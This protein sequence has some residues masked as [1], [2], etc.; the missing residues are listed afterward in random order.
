VP[1][2][3]ALLVA[4][5]GGRELVR[6][7]RREPQV[8]A[9]WRAHAPL[10]AGP[11]G[12][13]VAQGE[14]AVYAADAEGR[15]TRLDACS[16]QAHGEM[17]LPRAP[18]QLVLAVDGQHLLAVLPGR[19]V[20]LDAALRELKTIPLVSRDGRPV[21]AVA[22]AGEARARRSFVVAPLGLAE[23][24][25]IPHNPEAEPIFEGLVH[26]WRLGEGLAARGYLGVRRTRLAHALA[27]L[28][29][30][31]SYRHVLARPID[32]GDVASAAAGNLWAINLDVRL[33]IA[34]IA[35]SGR[36]RLASAVRFERDAGAGASRAMLGVPGAEAPLLAV[37]DL[38]EHRLAR[39]LPLP[40]VAA[41]VESHTA[42]PWLWAADGAGAVTLVDKSTLQAV[43]TLREPDGPIEKLG[44][45]ADGRRVWIATAAGT[46]ALLDAASLAPLKRTRLRA[47]L[48]CISGAA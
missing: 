37:I 15:L 21:S 8:E 23:L 10:A 20:I 32:E 31:V 17:R 19:L 42:S 13:A 34:T 11:Q 9:R 6:L 43:H 48:T 1:S 30:D 12:L 3:E 4:E 5:D 18:Q 47:P 26:D 41:D 35:A 44:F 27:E 38:A 14:S 2:G 25:E 36:L 45:S 7:S 33:V 40:A 16:L 46:L 29:L 28:W 24:W 22:H 39:T